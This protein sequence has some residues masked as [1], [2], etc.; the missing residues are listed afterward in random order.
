MIQRCFLL[1][2]SKKKN[3]LKN[4]MDMLTKLIS[5]IDDN[6][7]ELRNMYSD[8]LHF[9]VGDTHGECQTLKVLIERIAFDPNKDYVYFVGDYNAGGNPYALLDYIPAFIRLII[10]YPAFILSGEIMKENYVR[11]IRWTICRI[12]LLSG[13]CISVIIPHMPGWFQVRYI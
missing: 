4:G 8:G 2:I 6:I 5:C 7:D 1:Y 9:V 11:F 13:E 10:L 12:L 3:Q